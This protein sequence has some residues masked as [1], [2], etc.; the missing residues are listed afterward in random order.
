ML[1]LCRAHAEDKDIVSADLL[2]NFHI[3]TI[4]RAD[5]QRTVQH[6]LHIACTGS[7][8]A[9]SRNLLADICCRNH[10][11]CQRNTVVFHKYHLNLTMD[12]RVVIHHIRNSVNQLNDELRSVVACR[13]LCPENKGSGY[14]IQ[15]GVHLQVVIQPNDMQDIQQLS[16]I[17]MQTLHLNIKNGIRIDINPLCFLDILRQCNFVFLLDCRKSAAEGGILC[18]R[19]QRRILLEVEHLVVKLISFVDVNGRSIALSFPVTRYIDLR[20]ASVI[21]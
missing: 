7:L 1:H 15:S 13:R 14:H 17:F 11:F 9:R 21:E 16:F 2:A 10:L 19:H 6:K 18:I 4:H 3:C 20:P 8:L 12:G 5:C